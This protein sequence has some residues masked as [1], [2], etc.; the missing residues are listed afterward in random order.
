MAREMEADSEVR[1][2]RTFGSAR[3]KQVGRKVVQ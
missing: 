2:E 3:G 1:G